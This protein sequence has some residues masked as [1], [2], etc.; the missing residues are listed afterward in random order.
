MLQQ[1]A[2]S[3]K[4]TSIFQGFLPIPPEENK[5]EKKG[6]RVKN[7]FPESCASGD[8]MDCEGRTRV[9]SSAFQAEYKLK[10]VLEAVIQIWIDNTQYSLKIGKT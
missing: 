6:N 7:F 3:E 4:I 9:S 1:A 5:T 2:W 8:L 10:G